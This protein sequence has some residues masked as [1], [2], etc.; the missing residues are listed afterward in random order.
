MRNCRRADVPAHRVVAA[1]G[2]LGG[3]GG[4]E[5]LKRAMLAAEGIVM[6]GMRIPMDLFHWSPRRRPLGRRS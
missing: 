3:Y 4:S 5:H 1:G 6:H 2:R